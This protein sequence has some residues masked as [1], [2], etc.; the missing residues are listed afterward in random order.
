MAL[1]LA[2]GSSRRA[3]VQTT[4]ICIPHTRHYAQAQPGQAATFKSKSLET[5][6]KK[7][8]SRKNRLGAFRSLPPSQLTEPIFKAESS[9]NPPSFTPDILTENMIGSVTAFDEIPNDPIKYFGTPKQM[10]LEF[11][12]LSKKCSVIRNITV[13]TAQEL[14]SAAEAP[15][16]KTRFVLTGAE[17]SGKS[18]LL[19][20]AVR[21]CLAKGWIVIYVPRAKSLVNSTTTHTYDLRTQTY[22][23]P[24]YAQELL[25]RIHEVNGAVLQTLTIKDTLNLDRRSFSSGT[26]LAEIAS[27]GGKDATISSVVLEAF[28]N[29]L[30]Q[31]TQIPVLL[32]V[33][34]FQAVYNLKTAYRDPH[35]AAIRPFHLSIPRYLL[36]FA[37][38]KRFFQKG[39][40]LGALTAHDPAF[41]VP[42]ELMDQLNLPGLR[43]R[44]AYSK[45]SK[46]LQEYAQGL[47]NLPVPEEFSVKEA[48]AV[49]EMWMSDNALTGP[50]NDELFLS[51]YTESAGRPRAFVWQ[52]ILSTLEGTS[53]TV[54]ESTV[55]PQIREGRVP[56]TVF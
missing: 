34:D 48:A 28:L 54:D 26:T 2:R 45:R 10:L 4:F 43:P 13:L 41:P 30:S 56:L 38:G 14:D 44:T 47:Q 17:G 37:S 39:A 18:F 16:H 52:G 36:E 7:A 42:I 46:T 55:L 25:R 9:L 40:V 53:P 27:A 19:L 33:D 21:Y 32:A 1:A 24:N 49:F 50:A 29:E 35:F 11:R 12:L 23:Q 3:A 8:F 6:N 20:Q 22:L 51:K 5:K 15:S 31:Q